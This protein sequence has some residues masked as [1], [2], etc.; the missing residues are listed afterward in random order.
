MDI[1][2]VIDPAQFPESE[3][4]LWR[5]HLNALVEHVEKSYPGRVTLLRTRGQPLFCSLAEDFCWGKLAQGGPEIK[6]IP[7][8]HENIF[9]E[10]NVRFLA[11]ALAASLA[12][13]QSDAKAGPKTSSSIPAITTRIPNLPS[14]SQSQPVSRN[15]SH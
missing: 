10:P 14:N 15:E 3:L 6:L 9:M 4:Q 13:A 11:D 12:Q 8:S 1:E 7:G 2:E 5:I